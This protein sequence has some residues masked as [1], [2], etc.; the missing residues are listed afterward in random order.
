MIT[1][2]DQYKTFMKIHPRHSQKVTAVRQLNGHESYVS[3]EFVIKHPNSC[4]GLMTHKNQ[5]NTIF[6]NR[7]FKGQHSK[8]LLGYK[9]RITHLC[10]FLRSPLHYISMFLIF[11]DCYYTWFS[12]GWVLHLRRQLSH[13]SRQN[14]LSLWQCLH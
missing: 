2:Y 8:N 7:I 3:S 13:V 1:W 14:C 9:P 11:A 5:R 10:I 12:L 4:L 6:T